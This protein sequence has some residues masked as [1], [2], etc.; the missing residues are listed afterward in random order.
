MDRHEF[1]RDRLRFSCLDQGGDGPV[2]VALHAHFMEAV[3]FEPLAAALAPE[4]RFVAL[5]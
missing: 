2:L 3:T 5:D 4:W 1:R